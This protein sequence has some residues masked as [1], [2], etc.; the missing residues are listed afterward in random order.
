MKH[1]YTRFCALVVVT[2]VLTLCTGCRYVDQGTVAD[3]FGLLQG[4]VGLMLDDAD[5]G[6]DLLRGLVDGYAP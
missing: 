6:L 2:L 4:S 3:F 5:R 1:L